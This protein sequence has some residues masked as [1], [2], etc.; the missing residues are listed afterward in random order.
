M[1]HRVSIFRFLSQGILSELRIWRLLFFQGLEHV[2]LVVGDLLGT[3]FIEDFLIVQ[4]QAPRHWKVDRNLS[5][6]VGF[7]HLLRHVD[8]VRILDFE[9]R[10]FRGRCSAFPW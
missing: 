8:E 7:T 10:F 3:L 2:V 4:V 9:G 1:R 5:G 6:G